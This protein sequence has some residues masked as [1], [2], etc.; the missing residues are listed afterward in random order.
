MAVVRLQESP[1]ASRPPPTASGSLPP[2][3]P[4][5]RRRPRPLR[6]QLRPPKRGAHDARKTRTRTRG[7]LVTAVNSPRHTLAFAAAPHQTRPMP[8]LTHKPAHRARAGRGRHHGVGSRPIS[9]PLQRGAGAVCAARWPPHAR[10]GRRRGRCRAQQRGWDVWS[11]Q[12]CGGGPR[13]GQQRPSRRLCER[14]SRPAGGARLRPLRAS[15][16]SEAAL[17]GLRLAW[18]W[19]PVELRPARKPGADIRHP[20]VRLY[21]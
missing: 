4:P 19:C 2:R 15:S 3:L 13:G 1:K 10:A 5:S 11:V 17:G 20:Y 12:G 21:A 6:R 14:L 18:R 8:A 9:P 16:G 7:G